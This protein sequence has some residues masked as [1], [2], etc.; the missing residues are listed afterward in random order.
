MKID[1]SKGKNI[2]NNKKNRVEE[3]V[4]ERWMNQKKLRYI[5]TNLESLKENKN[6]TE[7][8]GEIYK[9]WRKGR[10]NEANT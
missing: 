9:K 3:M 8:V 7:E 4:R 10:E 6:Y 1:R 2:N 5:K